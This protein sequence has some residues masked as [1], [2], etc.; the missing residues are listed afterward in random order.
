MKRENR[1]DDAVSPVIGVMLM[2][3]VTIVIAAV[4][5]M[6]STGL[7]GDTK[8]TP[9]AMFEVS[10][11]EVSSSSGDYQPLLAY[12]NFRHKGGDV[13]PLEDLQ[14][15]FESVGGQNSGLILRLEAED[16]QNRIDLAGDGWVDGTVNNQ[17]YQ[18]QKQNLETKQ[19]ELVTFLE[20]K[21]DAA[22]VTKYSA[23]TSQY[24]NE[25][26]LYGELETELKSMGMTSSDIRKGVKKIIQAK[27]SALDGIAQVESEGWI[28]EDGVVIG[29]TGGGAAYPVSVLGQA[30]PTESTV[31]TGEIIHV[32]A[33]EGH[34][35]SKIYAGTSVKWTISY[36]PTNSI[37]AKGEFEVIAD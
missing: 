23:I 31:S 32:V 24:S 2:L 14:I 25:D 1:K 37:I 33:F 34:L 30:V 26:P 10:N 6:F 4:V 17:Y 12:V 22:N 36:I 21:F 8:T 3:V 7:A 20:S 5:V 13:I 29:K 19:A 35:N 16:V 28:I 11:V 9:T 27:E 15:Q 18:Q